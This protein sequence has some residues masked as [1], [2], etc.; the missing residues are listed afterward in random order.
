MESMLDFEEDEKV[1]DIFGSDES[2]AMYGEGGVKHEGQT[3]YMINKQSQ[4]GELY[5][6]YNLGESS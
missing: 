5:H 4:K 1:V 2:C 6:M 3:R